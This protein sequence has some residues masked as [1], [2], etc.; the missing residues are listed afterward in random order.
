MDLVSDPS[1]NEYFKDM[2]GAVEVHE[3]SVN[4]KRD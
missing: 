4:V 1:L 2:E 3:A